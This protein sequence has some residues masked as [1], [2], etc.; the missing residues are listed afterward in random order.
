MLKKLSNNK[1]VSLINQKYDRLLEVN[2]VKVRFDDRNNVNVIVP[3]LSGINAEFNMIDNY[4]VVR[5][6]YAVATKLKELKFEQLGEFIDRYSLDR[7]DNMFK[8]IIKGACRYYNYEYN[9]EVYIIPNC[10]WNAVNSAS[11][12]S[13]NLKLGKRIV[14]T[15]LSIYSSLL[16]LE[17][18]DTV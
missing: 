9:V 5:D 12:I 2:T 3:F 18:K 1:I 14:D 7:K 11:V 13:H 4:V 6:S 8:S 10:N 16:F 15:F 17:K